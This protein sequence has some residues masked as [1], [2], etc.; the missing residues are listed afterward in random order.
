MWEQRSLVEDSV[1]T[2]YLIYTCEIT[3]NDMTGNQNDTNIVQ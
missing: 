3:L 1:I 2:R